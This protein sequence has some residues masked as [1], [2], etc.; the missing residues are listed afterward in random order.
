MTI[1]CLVCPASIETLTY[2]EVLALWLLQ[3]HWYFAHPRAGVKPEVLTD[4]D[5]LK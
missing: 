4:G 1:T 2:S 5:P 3:C